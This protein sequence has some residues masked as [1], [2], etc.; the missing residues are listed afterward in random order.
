MKNFKIDKCRLLT[1]AEVKFIRNN[2]GKRI[3]AFLSDRKITGILCGFANAD[4]LGGVSQTVQNPSPMLFPI[5][6][7]EFGAAYN[8]P[9]ISFTVL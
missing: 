8:M 9:V 6:I 1:K 3:I 5:M 2:I 4:Y 7:R